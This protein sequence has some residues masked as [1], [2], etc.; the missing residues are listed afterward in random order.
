[1]RANRAQGIRRRFPAVL[2]GLGVLCFAGRVEAQ[3]PADYFR[4]NCM[5]CHT[6]GGGRV[7]GPDLKDVEQRKER[8][9]L[10]K[11]LQNPKALLDAGDPYA[12]QLQQ[13][14][15]GVVMPTPPQITADLAQALL[16]F[17]AAESK[18]PKSQFAGVAIPD[19]PFAP[20]EVVRGRE[21]FLGLRPLENRGPSCVGC[22]TLGTLGQLGGGRLGPDLTRVYE[23]L[24]GRKEVGTWLVAPAT[25][26]MQALFRRNAL[27]QEEILTL[28]A[29]L[30]PVQK[31]QPADQTSLLTFFL[32]GFAGMVAGLVA[33]QAAWRERFRAVRRPLVA[34]QKRGES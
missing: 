13:E 18:L 15:R 20:F 3:Q 21:L 10:I 27:T 30:E 31:S 11:F 7:T 29:Y 9:W 1:M 25:P 26:T 34:G 8:A 2:A 33:L 14:A 17:I 6:I 5:S 19:R 24:G 32:I 23:R 28:L 16:D 4:Q 12:L 22:H